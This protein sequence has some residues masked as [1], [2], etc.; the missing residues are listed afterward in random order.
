MKL[1]NRFDRKKILEGTPRKKEHMMTKT[2]T[3]AMT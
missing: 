2:S 1:D 3:G